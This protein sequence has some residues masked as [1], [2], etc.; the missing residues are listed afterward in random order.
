MVLHGVKVQVKDK[1]NL[2]SSFVSA[3]D[4]SFLKRRKKK[5]KSCSGKLINKEIEYFAGEH[6]SVSTK[7]PPTELWICK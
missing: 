2:S 7:N 1:L 6:Y 3:Q 5:E 4:L